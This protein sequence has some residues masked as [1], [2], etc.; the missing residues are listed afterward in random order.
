MNRCKVAVAQYALG[1]TIDTNLEQI[2]DAVRNAADEGADL[3]LL[4]ELGHLPYF[5]IEEDARYFSLAETIPGPA[6]DHY[7]GL[8][9]KASIIVVTTL[10]EKS[11]GDVYHNTAVVYDKDG[12]I[13]GTC[14]K[15]HIP[16]DP[17]YYEQFYFAEG[18]QGFHPIETSLGRLGVM[19]CFDQ[20]FPE[21]ARSMTLNGA[22]L[23]LYPSAIGFDPDDDDSEQIR[24]RNAWITIQKS[25]AIANG[26]PVLFSNRLGREMAKAETGMTADFWG[27]S[28]IVGPFGEVLAKAPVD[29][30]A[31]ISAGIDPEESRRVREIWPFLEMRRDG[32]YGLS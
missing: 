13:A 24:Q 21:A 30:P 15:M 18:T 5:C 22:E 11:P 19:I 1:H 20:W 6:S 16:N 7:A 23:L 25:H 3:V 12:S 32:F 10:F 31:V 4:P 8:A 9:R 2:A 17:G 29:R 28:H 14:R 27:S 26:I